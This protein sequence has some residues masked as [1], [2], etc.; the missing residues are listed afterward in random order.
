MISVVAPPPQIIKLYLCRLGWEKQ[1]I[2]VTLVGKLLGKL[3]LDRLKRRWEDN[4]KMYDK[5]D[6]E[7]GRGIEL[8]QDRA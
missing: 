1:G 6:C 3:L 4:I 2:Y 7:D 8:T 5:A